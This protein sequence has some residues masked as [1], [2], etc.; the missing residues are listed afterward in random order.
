[1]KLTETNI[2]I[3]A[4]MIGTAIATSAVAGP[5][6]LP[7][8]EQ[9]GYRDTGCDPDAMVEIIGKAGNLLYTNNPTCPAVQ[10]GYNVEKAEE[11]DAQNP[12]EEVKT[13]LN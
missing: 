9:N 5:F 4:I 10:D 7:D 6:G 3:A 8:H 12:N 13:A 11:P 1:M 2:T